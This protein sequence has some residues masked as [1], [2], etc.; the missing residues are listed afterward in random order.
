MEERVGLDRNS[1]GKEEPKKSEGETRLVEGDEELG[2]RERRTEG[3]KARGAGVG[4]EKDRTL[5][6]KKAK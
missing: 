5:I 2:N 1:D 3:R 6:K 4:K